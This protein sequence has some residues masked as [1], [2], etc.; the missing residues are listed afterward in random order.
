MAEA[1]LTAEAFA[2]QCGVSRETCDR[3]ALYCDLL[4][5]WQRAVNL[6][7]P[8]T[9]PDV[10]RRHFWD[11]AQLL[12][13]LPPRP[14]PLLDVGS[15]AGFPGMVLAIL[16]VET[17]TLVESDMRKGQFLRE[18]ARQTETPVTIYV[19]RLEKIRDYV[20]PPNFITARAVAPLPSLLDMVKLYIMPNTVC[21]F[22]KGRKVDAELAAA[23]AAWR[24]M[25]R[26]IPSA[27]DPSGVIL[28]LEGIASA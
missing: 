12:P 19:D 1:P 2:A 18:V 3:L 21:F 16:G 11:S 24:F 14:G 8:T 22:H 26:K 9:L 10:W 20:T 7:G 4:R 6:V 23:R 25:A 5:R 27:T 28:R 13:L 15:G 17:V